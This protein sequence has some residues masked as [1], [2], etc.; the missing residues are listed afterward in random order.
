MSAA[1]FLATLPRRSGS[2]APLPPQPRGPL[3]AFHQQSYDP[4]TG[5]PLPVLT[6]LNG[7]IPPLD[8]PKYHRSDL[9]GVTVPGLPRI[10]RGA[11]GAAQERMLSYL[12]DLYPLDWQAKGLKAHGQRGYRQFWLSPP[13]SMKGPSRLSI[14]QYRD[15]SW[16]V[17]DAGLRPCHMLR[18]KD[19][20]GREPD[21][22]EIYGLIEAL[23]AID[24]ID[25]AAHAWEASLFYS[26][27]AYR[28]T[29]DEDCRRFPM[30]DWC[31]HFQ[32][33][34]AHFGVDGEPEDASKR[35]AEFWEQNIAVGSKTL[36]YQYHCI[37][38][39]GNPAWTAGMMQA[40]GNDVSVRLIK[41]G[42]W[43]LSQT[44]KWV[45]FEYAGMTQFN[46]LHDA[47]NPSR[48]VD[49][50]LGN[51]LGYEMLCTYGPLAPS[52][53]C[54]GARMPDGAVI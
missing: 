48:L 2:P 34:Y 31:D 14:P 22:R 8:D 20:D 21:P 10:E 13:D 49:E 16:R 41:G 18:S 32:E 11:S 25:K 3:P 45:A 29:V 1:A 6:T 33:G 35:A 15:M 24:A 7:T 19:F 42:T 9:W 17:K 36:L 46:N 30:I 51:L 4:E 54:G 37:D 43:G 53:F 40:R 44:V 52:G 5:A 38:S 47:D 12:L 27:E 26:P 28:K 39:P 23:V 50:D